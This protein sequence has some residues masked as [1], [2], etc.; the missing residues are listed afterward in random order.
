MDHRRS[1]WRRRAPTSQFRPAHGRLLTRWKLSHRGRRGRDETLQRIGER[2]RCSKPRLSAT[3][4]ATHRPYYKEL[5][6][7]LDRV[8]GIAHITGGGYTENVPRILPP[9]LTAV[10]DTKAWAVPPIFQLI[11]QRGEIAA[12]EMYE[13]FN[14]GI[15]LVVMVNREEV[16]AVRSAIPEAI[17]VGRI[18]EATGRRVELRGL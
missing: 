13:V 18:V 11:Q 7:V 16:E 17:E 10:F 15:G 1:R 8:H 14:M 5:A 2:R 4:L 3:L 12:E 9:D 6:P